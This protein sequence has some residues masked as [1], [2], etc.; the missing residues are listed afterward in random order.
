MTSRLDLWLMAT[1]NAFRAT[2]IQINYE[3]I[4]TAVPAEARAECKRQAADGQ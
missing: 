1:R 4:A 2:L 3:P